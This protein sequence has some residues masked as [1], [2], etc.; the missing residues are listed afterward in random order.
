[1]LDEIK[2]KLADLKL[3]VNERKTHITKLSHGFTFLQIKYN[4]NGK[5][6]VKR[7]THDKIARERRRLKA[8]KRLVDKGKMT[9]IKAYNCYKSWRCSAIKDCNACENTIRSLD[10]LFS[11]LFPDCPT[12]V[13]QN[14]SQIYSE[15]LADVSMED[16]ETADF[17]ME[18]LDEDIY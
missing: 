7:L 12:K 14:R 18:Y 9:P 2:A 1:M 5:H 15:I 11:N 13:K 4:F 6:I 17:L 3:E 8:F 10:V 16:I